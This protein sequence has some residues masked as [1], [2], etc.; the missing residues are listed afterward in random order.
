MNAST[1]E[2]LL[3]RREKLLGPGN[4]L[5]YD[6]PVHIV[7]GEGVWLY[8]T[9]GRRYLDCY[10]NVPCVGHCHPYVVDALTRQAR[11]LNTHTRYLHETILD[12]AERLL[13]TFDRSFERVLFACTGSEA[14]DV[15]LRMA[16]MWSGG[17]GF[18]CTNATYHGNT[19]AVSKLS[20]IFPPFDGFGP[21]IRMVPWPDSYRALDNLEGEALADAYVSKVAEAVDSFKR[22]GIKLA[23]MLICPIFA[24]EGLPVIPSGYLEKAIR[25]VREAGGLYIADEVQAGFG[26]TG[27]M[28]GHTGQGATPDVVTLGKPMGAGHP[29]SGVVARADVFDHFRNNT[30]YFNT[31]GGNPVSCAAGLAVLDVIE[32]ENLVANA[33]ATGRYV[34]E[35]LQHLKSR[36]ECIGDVRGAGLFFGVDLVSDRE[37]KT[38]A[39]DLARHLVN[40]MREKGV[41]MGKIGEFD[42]VLKIRPPLPFSPDNAD[43][44]IALLDETL[45]ELTAALKP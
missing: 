22:A 42:N 38:P 21:N 6:H 37:R 15:A 1:T 40:T 33:A 30:M 10:N 20:S 2:Q 8:D 9:G 23:G 32:R 5:F 28:W 11:T 44:L 25:L 13:A 3:A 31:F 43:L 27:K 45:S 36:H 41:L 12:Y 29:I 14:N 34:Y 4:P 17:E 16:R 24:N 18:I 35:G 26:R 7:R 19:T 39:P